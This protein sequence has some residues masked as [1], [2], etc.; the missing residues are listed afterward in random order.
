MTNESKVV[1]R[2]RKNARIINSICELFQVSVQEATDRYYSSDTCSL[3]EEGVAD[4]H[5][6][7]DRYLAT[8]VWEESV[9]I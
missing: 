6:R 4:L 1:L 7:S 3:I 5:C 9:E 8:L 2:A